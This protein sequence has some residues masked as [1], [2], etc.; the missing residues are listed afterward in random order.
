MFII[1]RWIPTASI[2]VA[3]LTALVLAGALRFYLTHSAEQ[4]AQDFQRQNLFEINSIDTLKL[5][6]R[7]NALADSMNWVC[8]EASHGERYFF[9][10]RN[11]SC[12]TGLIKQ[13]ADIHVPQADDLKIAFTV[14]LPQALEFG[15][16]LFFILQGGLLV[17]LITVAKR[18]ERQLLKAEKALVDLATQTAHDLR[19]PLSALQLLT[20][21]LQSEKGETIQQFKTIAQRIEK[22]AEGLV[23][24]A[25]SARWAQYKEPL[26]EPASRLCDL[27]ESINSVVAEKRLTHGSTD[28]VHLEVA[29]AA[30]SAAALID[31]TEL[32]RAL[33]NLIQN[34]FEA[35]GAGGGVVRVLLE[36]QGS[37]WIISVID[38]G[39]GIPSEILSQ[40]GTK[41]ASF[42]KDSGQGSGLGIGLYHAKNTLE[43]AGGRL[44]I[45]SRPF[46]GTTIRLCIPASPT[47]TA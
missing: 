4:F 14:R 19:S 18:E 33:S 30:P 3:L 5:T 9:E 44:E 47:L 39:P 17:T 43:S 29:S 1:K 45:R 8:I 23:K 28:Q 6:A 22:I 37:E 41:G 31:P 21:Q 11:A 32:A 36:R 34:S 16:I 42:G 35:L 2:L 10:R 26:E 40:L 20:T 13:R 46:E 25:K 15:A 24:T 38:N 12:E 27:V 7:L